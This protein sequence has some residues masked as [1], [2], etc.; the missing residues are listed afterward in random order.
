MKRRTRFLAALIGLALFAA[1]CGDDDDDTEA[2]TESETTVADGTATTS[3]GG[4][5][6][7]PDLSACPNPLVIQKDWLAE[8]EHAPIYQL[9][10]PDGAM[11]ENQYKGTIDGTDLELTIIDG[12]PGLGEGQPAI[13]SLYAGNLK[14]NEEVHL[15]FVSTDDAAIYSEEFPV[16][17]VVSPLR[18]SP[19]ILFWDPATYPEGFESIDDL[20]AFAD[21]G[22]KI[23][24]SFTN[25][26]YAKWLIDQ[27]VPED[28]FLE[29][30]AGDAENF[31]TN[32]GKW[33]NQ[34]YASNEVWDFENGRGWAKPIDYTYVADFGYDFY[35]SALSVATEKLEELAP[36]LEAL[37]PM[38]QQA[39]VDYVADPAPINE[40]LA[41]YNEEGYGASY[42]KT[43]IE[44]NEAGFQVLIDDELIG[45]ESGS[46]AGFDLERVQA[47]ID[48]VSPNFD[49]RANPDV[50]PEDIATNEFIDTS[51]ALP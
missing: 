31:V 45:N 51:I 40:M 10:G 38:I 8:I 42:W 32:G 9:I 6:S 16:V 30:Y 3:G 43:P 5:S 4:E 19:S 46:I 33:I 1:A 26:S 49:E 21:T 29:G 24:V 41:T 15:A 27:G 20:V 14:T 23:Y 2:T 22:N 44:L 7:G 17:A 39:T 13:S 34:G 25:E 28:A 37:V 11:S 35:P 36:C 18:K 48:I 12:G 50:T 47:T